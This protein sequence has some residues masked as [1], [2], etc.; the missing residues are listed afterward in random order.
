[1]PDNNTVNSQVIPNIN[2]N[3]INSISDQP[4]EIAT[5]TNTKPAKQR[6]TAGCW[7]KGQTGNPNGRPK[8]PEI[9]ELRLALSKAAKENGRTFLQHLVDR[10]YKND[11]VAIALAK[12]LIPDLSS[13]NTELGLKGFRLV[14]ERTSENKVELEGR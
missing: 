8:R 6:K 4:N 1:M 14:I 10:S 9:E 3:I 13:V 11:T 7:K 2:N 12:K 5:V